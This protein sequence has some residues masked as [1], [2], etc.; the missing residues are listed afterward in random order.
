MAHKRITLG[1]LTVLA[2]AL[3]FCF[4]KK[5]L[6]MMK[7]KI[8]YLYLLLFVACLF[9]DSYING[10]EKIN[11]NSITVYFEPGTIEVLDKDLSALLNELN[12]SKKYRIE[13][14]SCDEDMDSK[15]E[16]LS[17]AQRRA[18]A[19][20]KILVDHGFSHKNI[21]TNAYDESSECKAI[22]VEME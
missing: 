11:K 19:V 1:L 16:Q 10:E 13:G 9:S 5:G 14:Y 20:G 18:E 6:I 15:V 17:S 8:Q 3:N 4:P 2:L 12:K 7:T 21:I 22:V